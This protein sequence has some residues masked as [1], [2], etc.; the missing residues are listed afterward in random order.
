MQVSRLLIKLASA[1]FIVSVSAALGTVC[2]RNEHFCACSKT[3]TAVKAETCWKPVMPIVPAGKHQRCAQGLCS[4][5]ATEPMYE[6]DCK[7]ASYCGI[8]K[9]EI[10]VLAP[11]APRFCVSRKSVSQSLALVFENIEDARDLKLD[12]GKCVFSDTE[13][14]CDDATESTGCV[15]FAFEDPQYGSTCKPRACKASMTCNCG[16]TE[17]CERKTVTKSVWKATGESPWRP[18]MVS[19]KKDTHTFMQ[20]SRIATTTTSI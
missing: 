7:G 14:T 6:C 1:A 13:C 18:D 5:N 2:I 3:A 19:C 4:V 11:V 20:V 16:G 17:L 15:D 10:D 8:K 12:T 9:V